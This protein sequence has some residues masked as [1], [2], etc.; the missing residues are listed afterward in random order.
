MD[1][2]GIF[3]EFNW[4]SKPVL[5]GLGGFS[6]NMC[7]VFKMLWLVVV[8]IIWKEGNR[9]I[10]QHKDEHILSMGEQVKLLVF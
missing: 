6:K 10:F 2:F 1:F 7:L 9:R 5:C 8:S 3:S 4:A